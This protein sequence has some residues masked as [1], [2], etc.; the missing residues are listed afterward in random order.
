MRLIV[1]L[2]LFI[3]Q[4]DTVDLFVGNLPMDDDD[5][6]DNIRNFFSEHGIELSDVRSKLE[7]PFGHVTL[8]KP[9]D[10]DKALGLSGEELNGNP[11]RIDVTGG[12]RK[13]FGGGDFGG[14]GGR[15]GGRGGGKCISMIFVWVVS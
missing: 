11:V 9:G 7:K 5:R 12:Q 10:K 3:L 8:A 6:L 15:G 14:L 2:T 4:T 1:D 13:S